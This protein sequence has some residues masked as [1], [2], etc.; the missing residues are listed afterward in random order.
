M[1][2]VVLDGHLLNPGDNPWT[3]LE[4]LGELLVFDRTPVRLVAERAANAEIVLT[5]KVPLNAESL[6]ALPQ[7]RF[8]S[9]LATGYNVVDVVAAAK[10]G[11]P[12]SNVPIYGTGTVAQHT[13]ALILELTN[14]VGLHNRSVHE[15]EWERA[16]DWSYWKS[17]V[18]ELAG[19][20][21]GLIGGGRIGQAVGRIGEALGMKVWVA[22]PT[23]K[24]LP[25]NWLGKSIEEIFQ[26]ADVISLHC[27]QTP[28]NAGFVNRALLS[29]M[30]P[31]AFLINTARGG[32]IVEQD[33]A[34]ALEAKRLAGAAVDVVSVEP[35]VSTNPLLRARNCIL[36]PHIAWSSLE[37]RRRLMEITVENV[38][39]FQR[40]API[41]RVN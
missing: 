27:P 12:V 29:T 30:K 3:K 21:L 33:M 37:A 11:I 38:C 16:L 32:L 14:Q 2:I 6:A 10:R 35:I 1:R 8:I 17:P 22:D 28:T 13:F 40:G 9:V 20:T 24:R 19:C 25:E 5:N 4:R 15:G 7:L 41:N 31:T 23:P 26:A 18:V 36:T 34:D 39:A